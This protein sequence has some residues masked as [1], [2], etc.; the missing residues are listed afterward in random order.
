M[1]MMG[2]SRMGPTSGV[3][4]IILNDRTGSDSFQI[5]DSTG[6]PMIQL[7]SAGDIKMKGVVKRTTTN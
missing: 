4:E 3:K 2:G 6:Y 1:A 7:T 5:K